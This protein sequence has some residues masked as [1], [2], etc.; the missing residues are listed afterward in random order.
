MRVL[1]DIISDI[2]ESC[3]VFGV[4]K[5]KTIGSAHARGGERGRGQEESAGA[6]TGSGADAGLSEERG[7]G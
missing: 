5:I 4:E 3:D 6:G 2:D 1:N 7:C